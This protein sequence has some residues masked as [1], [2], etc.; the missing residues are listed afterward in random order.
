MFHVGSGRLNIVKIS[1]L[2]KSISS[3]NPNPN[4]SKLF[5]GHQQIL[6]FYNEAKGPNGQ[7]YVEKQQNW[8]THTTQLQKLW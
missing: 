3:I 5:Y 6:K 4:T 7:L 8:R 1:L 2:P